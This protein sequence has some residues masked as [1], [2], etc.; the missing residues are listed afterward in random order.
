L[1]LDALVNENRSDRPHDPDALVSGAARSAT[2]WIGAGFEERERVI[3]DLL[4]LA[5]ALPP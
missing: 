4:E 1:L 5:D 3:R 2:Q